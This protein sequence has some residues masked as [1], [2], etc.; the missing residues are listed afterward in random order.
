MKPAIV[1]TAAIFSTLTLNVGVAREAGAQ[2]S[3][4]QQSCIN[5]LNTDLLKVASAQASAIEQCIKDGAK[6]KLSGTVEDCLTADAKG[7][8]Q[9][10]ADKTIADEA[11]KCADAPPFGATNAATVNDAGMQSSLDLI[12]DLFGPNLDGVI[13]SAGTDKPGA[14]CQ[15]AV[16][17]TVGQCRDAKLSEFNKCKKAGLKDGSIA[18][19]EDLEACMGDDPKGQIAKACTDP[20]GQDKIHQDL[21]KKCVAKGVDVAVAFP[22]CGVTDDANAT[23]ACIEPKIE[24]RVCQAL[25][26]A[27]GLN[28][29]CD[30]FDDGQINNSCGA[31]A[32]V[33]KKVYLPLIAIGAPLGGPPA[34]PTV[35]DLQ[36]QALSFDNSAAALQ[37]AAQQTSSTPFFSNL[38]IRNLESTDAT[39]AITYYQTNSSN[40]FTGGTT[41]PANGVTR[42]FAGFNDG[43]NT[44]TPFHGAAIL[45]S[46]NNI[47]VVVLQESFSP[48][49]YA[50]ANT[51]FAA[52][53]ASNTAI[54]P[55]IQCKN[56]GFETSFSVQNTSDTNP[57]NVTVEYIAGASGQNVTQQLTIP[58]NGA[59]PFDQDADCDALRGADD[60]F[61]GRAQIFSDQPVVANVTNLGDTNQ[62]GSSYNGFVAGATDVFMPLIMSNFENRSTKIQIQNTSPITA[63]VTF[64]YTPNTVPSGN[65]PSPGTVIVGPGQSVT[66]AQQ[67]SSCGTDWDATGSYNGA[68]ATTSTGTIVAIVT[69]EDSSDST[70]GATYSAIAATTAGAKL[71]FPIGF[72]NPSFSTIFKIQALQNNTLGAVFFSNT[73]GPNPPPTTFSIA[74][75]GGIATINLS[76][77]SNFYVGSLIVTTVNNTN[78][79]G[80]ANINGPTGSGDQSLSYEG[81]TQ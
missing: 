41:V 21:A 64:D 50:A 73:I 55:L 10:A 59:V 18:S 80:I 63:T 38:A 11:K 39:V 3:R 20:D 70:Q 36:F 30:E 4:Q 47:A 24:C 69:E 77:H 67:G 32:P 6:G 49:R 14:A 56:L 72:A 76:D 71:A 68:A 81:S 58:P 28:R 65:T 60:K 15:Q 48:Q 42:V 22:P 79:V 62:Y 46:A 53:Q 75:A 66:C 78:I 13:L 31:T 74:N 33:T 54:L 51:G 57:A 40:T 1:F 29:D 27:D 43:S 37:V 52:N 9:K 2:L 26:Q 61:V 12:H 25:N 45:E 17:A 5:T 19:A 34:A 8:V 16:A 35:A 23:H 7:K 44:P